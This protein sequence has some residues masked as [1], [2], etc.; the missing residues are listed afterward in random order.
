MII[1]FKKKILQLIKYDLYEEEHKLALTAANELS[2]LGYSDMWIYFAFERI[3]KRGSF[4]K[5]KNILFFPPFQQEVTCKVDFF[6]EQLFLCYTNDRIQGLERAKASLIEE[7]NMYEEIA[8]EYVLEYKEERQIIQ[9]QIEEIEN[10][11]EEKEDI[12]KIE[13]TY[14]KYCVMPLFQSFLEDI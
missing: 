12:S 8:I 14:S 10:A 11:I 2:E 1:D 3:K 9:N 7:N 4:L 13:E 5:N 6:R